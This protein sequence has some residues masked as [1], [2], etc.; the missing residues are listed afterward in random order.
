M[1]TGLC[2]RHLAEYIADYGDGVGVELNNDNC[3]DCERHQSGCIC[4][5]CSG[6]EL[7][8]DND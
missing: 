8:A 4:A 3:R 5:D 1:A 2:S 6:A 7:T